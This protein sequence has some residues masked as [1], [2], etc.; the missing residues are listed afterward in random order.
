MIMPISDFRGRTAAPGDDVEDGLSPTLDLSECHLFR[1]KF[2]GKL[3]VSGES[4][5]VNVLL[6]RKTFK[7]TSH[8]TNRSETRN[9]KGFIWHA[10]A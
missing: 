2:A 10:N 3:F 1:H 9:T 8:S 4:N 5:I 6:S 7:R